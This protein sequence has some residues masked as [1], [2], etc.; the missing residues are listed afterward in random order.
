MPALSGRTVTVG[1]LKLGKDIPEKEERSCAFMLPN[2]RLIFF[3]ELSTS[4]NEKTFP[5]WI[6]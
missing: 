5:A 4:L 6:N 3:A 1:D 2:D